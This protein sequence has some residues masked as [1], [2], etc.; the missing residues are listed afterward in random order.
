MISRLSCERTGQRFLTRGID[1]DGNAA[2][3]IETEQ[4][5]IV[6]DCSLAFISVRGSVPVF[7]EQPGLQVSA[8]FYSKCMLLMCKYRYL[9]IQVGSLKVRLSRGFKAT[10]PAY[11][12]HV[13]K[14]FKIYG[15][16]V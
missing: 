1:D 15:Q 9:A 11:D 7:W 12:R 13:N 2:N 16:L 10:Q 5:L 4:L 6:G 8:R 3:F 14:L